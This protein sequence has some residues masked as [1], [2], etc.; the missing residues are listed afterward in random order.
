[1]LIGTWEKELHGVVDAIIAMEPSAIVDMGGAE[2]Y[3]AVGRL[4]KLQCKN[5][6]V[7]TFEIAA[8][9]QRKLSDTA[10]V[11][12]V[13][14][15]FDIRGEA[16]TYELQQSLEGVVDPVIICDITGGEEMLLDPVRV[17][18]LKNASILVELHDV[19]QPNVSDTVRK[20]F[21][22]TH[23]IIEFQTQG[24]T[25]EDFPSGLKVRSS[26]SLALMDE[27]RSY[28][29]NFFWMIPLK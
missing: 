12:G 14:D 2:G 28:D 24:R 13:Q 10:R 4:T 7:I 17:P 9:N 18:S 3:Y 26:R 29:Q 16:T 1:M 22:S 6:K 11:N 20:R 25:V 5:T 15:L 8:E 21:R 19:I 27:L 23:K